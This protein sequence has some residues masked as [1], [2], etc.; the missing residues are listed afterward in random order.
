MSFSERFTGI[1]K[2]SPALRSIF[3]RWGEVALP[4]AWIVAG[5]LAQT[6]WNVAHGR[7][8]GAGIKDID[9]VYFDA[10]DLS[11]ESEIRHERRLRRLF[12]DLAL[13]IDVKNEARVHLWY[14]QKFGREIRPYESSADAIASFPTT[15]TCVGVQ[16]SGG[17]LK[18]E[19]PFGLDDLM[20]MVVRPN[21]ALVSREIYEAKTRR[22]SLHWPKLDIRPWI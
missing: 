21:R 16:P 22:W 19:A 14:G 5:A 13:Q 4:D 7:T 17:D 2:Q 1:L 3:G 15:A 6:V 20:T 8:P 9:I 11:A 18:I 10:G 12:T